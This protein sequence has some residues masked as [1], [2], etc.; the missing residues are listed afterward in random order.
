[1]KDVGKNN[2]IVYKLYELTYEE[3]K[4]IDTEF[5]ISEG[6]YGKFEM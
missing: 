3:I 2:I 6:Y 5:E 4:I 1:M